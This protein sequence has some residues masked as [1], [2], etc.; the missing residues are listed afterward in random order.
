MNQLITTFSSSPGLRLRR[1]LCVTNAITG[2]IFPPEIQPDGSGV[3][4]EFG[5]RLLFLGKAE[6][7]KRVHCGL[8]QN[9]VEINVMSATIGLVS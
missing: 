6:L 4:K 5:F 9:R 1:I 8:Q 7:R 3:G 2:V